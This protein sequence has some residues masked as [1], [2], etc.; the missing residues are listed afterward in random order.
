MEK[1]RVWDKHHGSA[2]QL[3]SVSF[4][5]FVLGEGEQGEESLYAHE[6]EGDEGS[7]GRGASHSGG[8]L[9]GGQKGVSKVQR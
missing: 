1:I 6:E 5:S 3:A 2:T 9:P 4:F 8:C 7:H